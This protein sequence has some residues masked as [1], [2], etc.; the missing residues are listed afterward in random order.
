MSTEKISEE[1]LVFQLRAKDKKAFEY[2]YD[3][4]SAAL[5]GVVFRVINNE[6]SA[7]DILQEVFVKIWNN[8]ANYNTEK[9]KL[10]TWMLNIAR[11]AAID[12]TRNKH[13]KV[14]AQIQ[15][16]EDSVNRIDRK[17]KFELHVDAIGLKDVLNKLNHDYRVLIDLA[18]F[19]GYTQEEI[20]EELNLPLGTVKT[21]IRS[22]LIQLR[23]LMNVN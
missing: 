13:T 7:Q 17:E 4:Y 6:E 16:V 8:F 10:F 20:S 1:E 3:N 9:G 19:G 2:L 23:K 11:N 14:S 22:A 18:Y 12:A 15:S 5:Y 21:R